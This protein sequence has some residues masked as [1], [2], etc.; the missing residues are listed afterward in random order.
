MGLFSS[1]LVLQIVNYVNEVFLVV[2]ADVV[3]DGSH[4]HTHHTAL[5]SLL[6][7]PAT[8]CSQAQLLLKTCLLA[9]RVLDN[10]FRRDIVGPSTRFFVFILYFR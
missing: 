2:D 6:L 7:R 4:F 1:E 3:Y 10:T 9:V 5:L 8:V